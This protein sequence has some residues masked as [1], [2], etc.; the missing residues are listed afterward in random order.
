MLEGRPI[1]PPRLAFRSPSPSAASWARPR[2][3]RP[4]RRAGRDGDG[5]GHERSRPAARASRRG[6]W[7]PSRPPAA[8]TARTAPAG[9]GERASISA[10]GR[11]AELAR[12]RRG[13]AAD[14]VGLGRRARRGWRR[15]RS[16]SRAGPAFSCTQRDTPLR[17]EADSGSE[18]PAMKPA[19]HASACSAST[20]QLRKSTWSVV[21]RTPASRVVARDQVHGRVGRRELGHHVDGN[22]SAD[23]DRDAEDAPG[24][25]DRAGLSIPALS[26]SRVS[27]HALDEHEVVDA[28]PLGHRH[29]GPF[30]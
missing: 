8:G 13:A 4:R 15:P 27:R 5:H 10:P 22:S 30:G 28:H 20:S 14:H 6:G 17:C 9:R 26:A 12:D 29:P 11:G 3:R 23:R 19:T 2:P 16:R 18:L 21:R 25:Q 24:A 7:P 1:G